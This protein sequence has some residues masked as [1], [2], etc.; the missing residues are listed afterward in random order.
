MATAPGRSALCRDLPLLGTTQLGEW[1]GA[2]RLAEL[3]ARIADAAAAPGLP[4]FAG[5][6]GVPLP[7]DAPGRAVQLAHVLREHRGGLHAIAVLAGGLTPLQAV[8]ARDDGPAR[9]RFL[10]WPEPYPQ[11]SEEIRERRLAVEEL[12]DDLAAPAYAVLDDAQAAELKDLLS[13][14]HRLAVLGQH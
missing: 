12:T 4:L 9:A 11:V 2:G 13:R 7:A 10:R 14:A 3:L 6:R 5:W 8:L 1:S